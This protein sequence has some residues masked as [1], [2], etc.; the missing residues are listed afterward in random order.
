MPDIVLFDMG[1]TLSSDN[2]LG[3]PNRV[4]FFPDTT[5]KVFEDLQNR[6]DQIIIFSKY[7]RV[8]EIEAAL[9]KAKIDYKDIKIVQTIKKTKLETAIEYKT[10]H[11]AKNVIIV[12]DS[13]SIDDS[14][15]GVVHIQVPRQIDHS[16]PPSD[17]YLKVAL[18]PE[19]QLFA[20][21]PIVQAFKQNPDHCDKVKNDALSN[22]YE[23]IVKLMEYRDKRQNDKRE[24]YT[25]WASWF[26][27]ETRSRT[28]KLNAVD[29][30]VNSLNDR[31][32]DIKNIPEAA[33]NGELASIVNSLNVVEIAKTTQEIQIEL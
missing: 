22:Y 31:T 9:T 13:T 30:I 32:F 12:D 8:R 19:R 20:I 4:L 5:K 1:D 3:N 10:S 25:C 29:S 33:K 11:K 28:A 18:L 26:G 6:G 2:Q 23:A 7:A 14:S 16:A 24:Y 17:A 27:S 15:D 21:K